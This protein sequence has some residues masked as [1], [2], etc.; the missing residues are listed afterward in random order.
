MVGLFNRLKVKSF[1]FF[2]PQEPRIGSYQ[3][4]KNHILVNAKGKSYLSYADFAVALIDEI[5]H[6]QHLNE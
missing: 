6:P 1:A 4:G 3:K 5:E 2:D